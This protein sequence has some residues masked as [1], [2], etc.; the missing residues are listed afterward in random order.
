M[1]TSGVLKYQSG[2]TICLFDVFGFILIGFYPFWRS[3]KDNHNNIE[4]NVEIMLFMNLIINSHIPVKY[5]VIY[6]QRSWRSTCILPSS[7]PG[8][9]DTGIHKISQLYKMVSLNDIQHF[10]QKT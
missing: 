10:F 1:D 7:T 2:E 6:F 4:T 3:H 8:P 9:E 5:L